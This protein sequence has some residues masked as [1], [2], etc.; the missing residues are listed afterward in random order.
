MT[1]VCLRSRMQGLVLRF[2]GLRAPT[3]H[4][5]LLHSFLQKA[6]EMSAPG[7]TRI[8][9]QADSSSHPQVLL[10]A[11]GGSIVYVVVYSH[12]YMSG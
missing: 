12:I 9:S 2:F 4:V 10:A 5:F 1:Y 11:L 8:L 7:L 6:S 3:V